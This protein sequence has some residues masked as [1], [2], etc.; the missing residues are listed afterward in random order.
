MLQ[1]E[2][3]SQSAAGYAIDPQRPLSPDT[4][5]IWHDRLSGPRDSA[6]RRIWSQEIIAKVREAR[7][8]R[9]APQAA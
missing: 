8:A 1:A 2:Y 3:L 4:L 6:G 5:R 9:K 7:A